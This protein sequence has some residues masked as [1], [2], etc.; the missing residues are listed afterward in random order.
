LKAA[1]YWVTGGQIRIPD[2]FTIERG[3]CPAA[4]APADHPRAFLCMRD[5]GHPGRHIAVGRELLIAAWPGSHEPTRADLD[6]TEHVVC[7]CHCTECVDSHCQ[8]CAA[9]LPQPALI[10][11]VIVEHGPDPA[12]PDVD[13]I[14]KVKITGVSQSRRP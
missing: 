3:D 14:S 13:L 7:D 1:T 2:W 11:A 8:S 9:A 12:D 6:G 4:M 5:I 10:E